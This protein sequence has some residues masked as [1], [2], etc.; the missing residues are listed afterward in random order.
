MRLF[1]DHD[2]LSVPDAAR[3]L[4]AARSIAH[5]VLSIFELRVS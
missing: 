3:A 2:T 1:L 5:R 4:G